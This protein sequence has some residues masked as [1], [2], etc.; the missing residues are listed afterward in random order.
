M[1]Y[2]KQTFT[3]NVTVLNA[4]MMTHIADG[5]VANETAIGTAQST[6]TAAQNTANAACPKTQAASTSALGLVKQCTNVP[7]AAGADN[8]TKAEFDALIDAL[9]A[10]GIMAGA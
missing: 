8:V 3:D 2:S 7:K 9:V 6:A 4:S 1:A 10:A 5:I